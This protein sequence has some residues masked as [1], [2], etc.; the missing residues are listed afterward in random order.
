MFVFFEIKRPSLVTI[1][2]WSDPAY[3][4]FVTSGA[5]VAFIYYTFGQT[6]ASMCKEVYPLRYL[7]YFQLFIQHRFVRLFYKIWHVTMFDCV[8]IKDYNLNI[9]ERLCLLNRW[10][11]IYLNYFMNILYSRLKSINFIFIIAC[12]RRWVIVC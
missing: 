11:E 7:I 10:K 9:I 5:T 12:H 4:F 3:V 8:L 6:V 2:N 1:F